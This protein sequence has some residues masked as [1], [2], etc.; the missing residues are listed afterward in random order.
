[1]LWMMLNL[2]LRNNTPLLTVCLCLKEVLDIIDVRA[3]MYLLVLLILIKLLIMSS[4][5]VPAVSVPSIQHQRCSLSHL[6]EH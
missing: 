3:A 2:G 5:G 1:M 4:N 6:M